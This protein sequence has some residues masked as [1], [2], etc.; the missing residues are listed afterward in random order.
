MNVSPDIPLTGG[1]FGPL[2]VTTTPDEIIFP[3]YGRAVVVIELEN[4]GSVDLNELSLYRRAWPGMTWELL[5]DTGADYARVTPQIMAYAVDAEDSGVDL[6]PTTLAA[7]DKVKIYAPAD[8]NQHIMLA[9][10][11]AAS[12]TTLIGAFGCGD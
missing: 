11:T 1:T 7:T 2:E 3:T 9:P 10:A 6:D 4:T 8:G 12:T 5:N